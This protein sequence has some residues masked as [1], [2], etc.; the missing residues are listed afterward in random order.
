[1]DITSIVWL[2]EIADKLVWKHKVTREEVREIFTSSSHRIR[3]IEKGVQPDEDVYA[4]LG[5]T[6]AGRYLIV[7]FVYKKDGSALI[8]SGRD[9][10]DK[11]R[12]NYGKK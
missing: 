4:V 10:S 5:K 3:F 7:F 6:R 12:K 2:E 8:I 1:L 9:M 11:E